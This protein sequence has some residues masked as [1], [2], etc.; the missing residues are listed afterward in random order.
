MWPFR[1]KAEASP[2]ADGPQPAPGPVIRRDWVGAP[3]TQ[4]LIG[5]HPL[6][7][8][9]ERFSHDLATHHD[10]SISTGTMGHQVSAEAPAGIVLALARPSTRSDGPAMI[11]RPGVQRRV[12]GAVAESG[13]WDGDEAASVETRPSPLPASAAAVAVHELRVV[14]PEPVA[15][16]LVS[17]SPDVAPIPVPPTPNRSRA[18]STPMAINESPEAPPAPRL[19]LGQSR[20]LGLGPPIKRVA[21][22]TVQRAPDDSVLAS[23][24][25]PAEA[26]GRSAQGLSPSGVLAPTTDRVMP[27]GWLQPTVNVAR[28]TVSDAEESPRQELPLARRSA[29]NEPSAQRAASGDDLPPIAAAVPVEP[30]PSASPNPPPR[31]STVSPAGVQRLAEANVVPRSSGERGPAPTSDAPTAAAAASLPPSTLPL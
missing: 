10:P 27:T 18:I 28:A 31:A 24:S 12:D 19:T 1:R 5:E 13:E 25:P 22:R 8:P 30:P 2:A 14:T 7:A 23:T 26:V 16:R 4:R 6:T 15:Q 11:P 9:S 29:A 20:R 3:R 17:L 21:D